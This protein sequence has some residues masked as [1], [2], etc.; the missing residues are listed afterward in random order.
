MPQQI[1]ESED[2]KSND[3]KKALVKY[4]HWY[5]LIHKNNKL[6]KTLS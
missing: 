3:C 4:I 6:M 2:A 5:L 1:T